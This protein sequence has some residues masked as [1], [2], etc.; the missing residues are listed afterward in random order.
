MPGS[1]ST[2]TLFGRNLPGGQDAGVKLNGR[3]LQ[4]LNV[5]I[6]L[7]KDES[8]LQTAV[9]LPSAEAAVDAISYVQKSPQGSSNPVQIYLATAPVLLE[10]EPND[11]PAQAQKVTVPAEIGGQ[12]QARGDTDYFDF[13]AKAGEVYYI[14]VF[15]QRNGGTADPYFTLEQVTKNDQ[16]EIG[17]AHV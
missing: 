9:L 13:T 7:P 12:F 11:E 16:G 3:P 1:T 14:E 15:G 2:Y 17:R 6:S 10:K 4:K 5:S 8:T